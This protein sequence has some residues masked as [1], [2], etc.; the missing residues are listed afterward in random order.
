MIT[1]LHG[2]NINLSRE[3]LNTLKIKSKQSYTFTHEAFDMEKLIQLVQGSGLFETVDSIFFED[4]L[5]GKKSE[6]FS[7][8]EYVNTHEK[9]SDFIFW[10]SKK[11]TAK[12]IS[13]FKKAKI[14]VFKYPPTLFAFLDGLN[15]RDFQSLIQKFHF[16]LKYTSAEL[17]FFMMIR[18]FRLMIA[19]AD[20]NTSIQIDEIKNLQA[21][22]KNKLKKQAESFGISNLTKLYKRLFTIESHLKTGFL[23]LPIE[24][25]IDF[26]LLSI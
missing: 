25:Q 1:I 21:W 10:E 14:Q 13:S 12:E 15:P 7:L 3:F 8:I 6:Y 17:I 5:T 19:L 18:Q 24:Y 26:F 2:E 22:Q 16:A 11:L 23:P 4:F 20:L 9:Q